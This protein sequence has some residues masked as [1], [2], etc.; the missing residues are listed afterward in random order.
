MPHRKVIVI[1]GA[2]S[3]IGRAVALQLAG[4][5]TKLVLIARR[6]NLL[7]SLVREI[8][9]KASTAVIVHGDITDRTT[10]E[11]AVQCCLDRFGRLDVLINNAGAGFF[12]EVD[13]TRE[14]DLDRM[15]AVNFKGAF[16][17]VRAA[18][19]VM[20]QQGSGHVINIAS[21]AGRRG[22]P[23][24]GAYCASKFALVGWTESLRSEL[25][26]SG[27]LVSL[28]CPGATKTEFFSSALR[29]TAHHEGLVGPIEEVERVAARIVGIVRHPRA[30]SRAQPFRRAVFLALNLLAP[31][32]VDRLLLRLVGTHTSE[33]PAT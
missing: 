18:L 32:L 10:M 27:I 12:A 13:Q 25:L 8:E 11:R 19:P 15:L 29:R 26:P 30:E 1:T 17:G 31:S 4:K 14:E 3:G 21:T 7:Q 33:P 6:L 23:Y 20:R 5:D 9:T 28:I 2:S 22:S 24:V 16:F